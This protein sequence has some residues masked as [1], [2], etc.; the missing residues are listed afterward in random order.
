M[1][2][3][4]KNG[5][6]CEDAYDLNAE[7]KHAALFTTGNGY[8]GIR[9][10]FEEFGSSR[11][12]GAY[13]RGLIDEIVEVMEPF[14]DNEYMKKFYFDEQALKDFEKQD[15]C[16][17]FA[18]P[19]LVRF[20][21]GGETFYPWEGKILRWRRWLDTAR[22]ILVRE[23]D[24]E[25]G[26]G[27]K[28][29]FRF[30]R[31]ASY[32]DE[33]LYVMRCTAQPLNHTEDITIVSGLDTKVR[34]GGQRIVSCEEKSIDGNG[35]YYRLKAGEKYGFRVG[36]AVHSSFFGGKVCPIAYEKDGILGSEVLFSEPSGEVGVT[37][38]CWINISRDTDGDVGVPPQRLAAYSGKT[39]EELLAEHLAVWQPLF[40]RF[41]IKIGGDHDADASLRFSNYHT[42]ISAA[43]HDHVHGLSAKTLSG[44][45]YNQFVWWDAEIYQLPVFRFA[46]PDV[47]KNSLLYRCG[48]LADARENA[49]ERGFAGAR[50]PFVASVG[51]REKVWKYARHPHLQV[52]ITADIGYAVLAYYYN[53][54][55]VIFMR[56]H[57]YELLAD[58]LRYWVSRAQ[59]CGNTY[60]FRNVTG[61]DEHHPYVNNDAY[62]NYLVKYVFE[63]LVSA[64]LQFVILGSGDRE[65][66]SFFQSMAGRYPDKVR[67]QVGFIPELA[68]KIYAGSDMF[69][70][71]SKSEPCG[72]SQ[73]VALR[74][75]SIPIVRE[76]G[77]LCD[78]IRDSGDGEGNGFTFKSYNAND[79]A[80]AVWRAFAGYG[81]RD[82]WGI[83]VR[84]AMRCDN[85]WA[86]SASAYIDLYNGLWG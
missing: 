37:K 60:E 12:Q 47:M 10:S 74:Y 77:G 66:E 83:L 71:P 27:R 81:D 7:P 61:T 41:D 16:I 48:Q 4:D 1:L 67:I 49:K 42:V 59:L 40:A 63:Q 54:L 72:L 68:H 14:P 8:M 25:D 39:F 33:H 62:T 75:G 34:T 28:T 24:W 3:F 19:L 26:K 15:S 36:L 9:G 52:H 21:V 86:R 46:M 84:R 38:L 11:V 6:L 80:N 43:L 70:M 57:G 73:M 69:L 23:T 58:V 29:R 55:D 64:D 82:G 13:I 17:N 30:E 56:E 50:F 51:G 2:K 85:S 32:A 5:F 20:T 31:F 78:T 18:D 45:R 22:A 53:T 65:Y 79:M 35:L 76:T 44:E